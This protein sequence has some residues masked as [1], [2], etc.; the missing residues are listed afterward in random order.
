PNTNVYRISLPS[1][2]DRDGS[3]TALLY[4]NRHD[5]NP[6]ISPDGKRITFQS[7]RTGWF[8]I[9]ICD[10][11]G[12]NPRQVTSCGGRNAGCPCWSPDGRQIVFDS[13]LKGDGDIYV[14]DA[15]GGNPRRLTDETSEDTTPS[16]SRDGQW[17]YFGSNRSGRWEV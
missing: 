13:V 6:Q 9:W 4:S 16:W 3:S 15:E 8:D 5:Y 17:V 1:S 7:D 11:D 14:I 10:S 12:S 2:P